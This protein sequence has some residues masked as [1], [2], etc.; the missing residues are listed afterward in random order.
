MEIYTNKGDMNMIK[1]LM[2]ILGLMT[3]SFV[4]IGCDDS[5]STSEI[6]TTEYMTTGSILTTNEM[7][8][9]ETTTEEMTTSEQTTLVPTTDETTTMSLTT[10]EIT[11]ETLMVQDPTV[12]SGYLAVDVQDGLILHAWN[13]SLSVIE[14]HLEE[15]AIAGFSTIQISPM[16]P[17]KDYFGVTS[18]GEGWWR[19]YQ[20]LG[21]VI[22][23]SDHSIGTLADLESLT[24]AA[25]TYGIKIIV[26]IVANH[27]ASE[28]S[29]QLDSDVQAYEPEIYN[30]NLIRTG[31]GVTSDS[32][33]YSVTKGSLGAL[34]DLKTE[35]EIVQQAVLDLLKDYVDAGV[36][37]FRFDAA[38]HIETDLDGEYASDFWPTIIHGIEAYA[39]DD[40]YIYGEIL[41]TVGN[42]RSYSDYT[43]YMAITTNTISDQIRNAV[44]TQNANALLSIS[45]LSEVSANQS[46]IWPESHDDFAA[47]HTD[48][49]SPSLMNKT[50]VVEA[51]RADVTTL[52][53]VR[54]SLS[55]MMGEVGSYAWQVQEVYEI[56]RFHNFFIDASEYISVENGFFINERYAEDKEGIVIVDIE[57]TSEVDG[58]TVHQLSDGYYMDQMTGEWFIVSDGQISGH[59]GESGI[60]IIYNNPYEPKPVF[61]VS[62]DGTHSTF[63]DTL[64]VTI[65]SYNTTEAYYSINGGEQIP[66]SNAIDV[67]L[68]D[69]N[70]NATIT[71]DIVAY[72]GDYQVS[73]SYEYIKSNAVIDEVIVNNINPADVE[74][75]Q[76]YVW[77]WQTGMN[78]SWV[79]GVYSD[80]TYTFDLPEGND[81][82]L[83]VL[84][85][86]SVSSPVWGA[87]DYQTGDIKVP[88]DGIFDATDLEWN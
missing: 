2:I 80:G 6:M 71:L 68:S 5:I 14:D 57:G 17:Q 41:N 36:D 18:W 16:Q 29:S 8:T 58:L 72:Y 79:Q 78:G 10:G 82:F 1:K 50:Y 32:S 85:P 53:F 21:F 86:T 46:V 35:E 65:Y 54:P 3:F 70:A 77:T 12:E 40:L 88:N 11:T 30:Q 42:G 20:P 69:P 31:N 56:N 66:F 26:D 67:E 76:I 13:W 38:K 22:A 28:S 7:T 59:I 4:F 43:Q 87:E 44:V 81:Y 34:V 48:G 83:L 62:D 52:Y 19:L 37:G 60:A 15:I 45:Y 75:Y 24:N 39:T 55:T 27:L 9:E 73:Q 63:T 61:Y 84:F 47:G 23:T 25:D 64:E 33:V 74:G 49:L 51:S